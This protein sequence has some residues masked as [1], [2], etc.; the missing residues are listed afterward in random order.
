M[1]GLRFRTVMPSLFT[2]SGRAGW[3][4]LTRFCTSRE[5]MLTSVPT[6]KTTLIVLCPLYVL[7]LVIYDI[8]GVPL[9]C[10]S[11]GVVVVCSTVLA[12]APVKFDE[13]F[14]VGGVI[15]GYWAIGK[16]LNAISPTS[17]ITTEIT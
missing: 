14:T 5:A 12:S 16:V 8:P 3:A 15:S 7:L 9:T 11:I 2:A 13:M 17:I 4:I 10:V 6:S 1:L